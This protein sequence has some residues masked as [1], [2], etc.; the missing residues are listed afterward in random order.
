MMGR[1][2]KAVLMSKEKSSKKSRSGQADFEKT[3]LS[4]DDVCYQFICSYQRYPI[5]FKVLKLRYW[6]DFG[7][8][9]DPGYLVKWRDT[10]NRAKVEI[11]HLI[12]VVSCNEEDDSKVNLFT[13]S[14]YNL[15]RKLMIQ[16]SHKDVWVKNE[17][18]LLKKLVDA[19]SED[20]NLSDIYFLATG[21]KIEV[22]N[23]DLVPSDNEEE[24]ELQQLENSDDDYEV[25]KKILVIDTPKSKLKSP[26]R[27]KR[28]LAKQLAKL[29]KQRSKVMSKSKEKATS[30]LNLAVDTELQDIELRMR[31]L[32]E[33]TSV[34][35]N[36]IASQVA[37]IMEH[38]S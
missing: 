19:Y 28:S 31:N 35:N 27:K 21:T 25:D 16:G 37:N 38:E 34:M 1:P 4:G 11:Q 3:L 9:E 22:Q 32:E 26:I 5:W 20:E 24:K 7:D 8:R 36:T 2:R 6:L 17:F 14:L 30:S 33:I 18:Q 15:K 29:S 13:L 23:E 12:R 10:K